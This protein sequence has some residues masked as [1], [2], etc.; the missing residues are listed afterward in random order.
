MKSTRRRPPLI[1]IPM[2]LQCQPLVLSLGG[3]L[4]AEER[5]HYRRQ[6]MCS[7]IRP[8]L[9]VEDG[10]GKLYLGGVGLTM[11]EMLQ[12]LD[13]GCVVTVMDYKP[14][15]PEHVEHHFFK[16]DDHGDEDIKST[17]PHTAGAID[18]A[19]SQGKNVLVHCRAGRSRSVTTV[20]AFLMLKRRM[21]LPQASDLLGAVYPDGCPNLSFELMLGEL[22]K[23]IYGTPLPSFLDHCTSLEDFPDDP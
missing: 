22:H 1:P 12:C 23:D 18:E 5:E 10:K 13:I 11:P 15:I 17:F 14:E 2:D 16:L 20:L 4:S 3:T 21:T 9:P 19:L 7:G 6:E 8:I